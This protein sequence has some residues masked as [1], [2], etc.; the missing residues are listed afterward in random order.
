MVG[1]VYVCICV[2]EV[3]LGKHLTVMRVMTGDERM[4]VGEEER[5]AMAK[6]SSKKRKNKQTGKR[7]C[8][9]FTPTCM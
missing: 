2:Q 9:M 1:C 8:G 7:N 4:A 5:G 6:G 3:L